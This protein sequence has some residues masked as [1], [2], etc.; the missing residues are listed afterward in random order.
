MEQ[1]FLKVDG[2][3][4]ASTSEHGKGEIEVLSYNYGVSMPITHS[5]SEGQRT[6]GQAN[7]Q[8]I[9]ISKYVDMTTPL[10]LQHC[11]KGTLIKTMTLRHLRADT[12]GTEAVV[13]MT[14]DMDEA[15]VT[16]VSAGGA[17]Q[18][19]ETLSFNFSKIQWTYHKQDK[20]A[21]DKGNV[22]ASYDIALNKVA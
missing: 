16:S 22:V 9:T 12:A 4:G 14:I 15:L 6:H 1:I 7:V 17:D 20:T 11:C 13:L 19:V 18:P 8:D 21:A 10:F 3:A 2:I 5:V